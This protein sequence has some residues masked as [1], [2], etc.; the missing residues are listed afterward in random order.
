MLTVH[1]LVRG[2][3]GEIAKIVI[4]T[5]IGDGFQVLGIS[6]MG[7]AHTGDLALL[8]HTDRLLFFHNGIVRKLIP[9]DPATFLDQSD[10]PFCVGIRLGDLIQGLLY[11]LF[12]VHSRHSFKLIFCGGVENMQALDGTFGF[13][14]G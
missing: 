8:C 9:G 2:N 14:K 1:I 12:S 11:K 7:D 13:E 6:P 5:A 4:L 10:D 3:R